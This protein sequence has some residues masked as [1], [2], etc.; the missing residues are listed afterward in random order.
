MS[1]ANRIEQTEALRQ[2]AEHKPKWMDRYDIQ[3]YN[4]VEGPRPCIAYSPDV[5]ADI[6]LCHHIPV[7]ENNDSAVMLDVVYT[8]DEDGDD[9][10]DYDRFEWATL[11]EFYADL[12]R[13]SDT[14]RVNVILSLIE[15]PTCVVCDAHRPLV[16]RNF[17]WVCEDAGA[18]ND[19]VVRNKE[20]K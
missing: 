3:G 18:C 7:D 19:T 12:I 4:G 2:F 1:Y 20:G 11:E 17:L 5:T 8:E 16:L 10:D 9:T 14:V 15:A 6:I 13:V